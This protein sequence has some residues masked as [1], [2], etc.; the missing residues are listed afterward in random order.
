[1]GS[2]IKKSV[3]LQVMQAT[4]LPTMLTFSRSRPWTKEQIKK[5]QRVA[6]YAVRRAMGMD[7]WVMKDYHVADADMHDLAGWDLV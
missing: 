6:N 7:I 5:A 3:R 1:M 4:V 2:K